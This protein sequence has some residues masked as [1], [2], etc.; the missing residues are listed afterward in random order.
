VTVGRDLFG[1]SQNNVSKIVESQTNINFNYVTLTVPELIFNGL[2]AATC[3][4]ADSCIIEI[5]CENSKIRS[6]R[7]YSKSN[8]KLS[9]RY[10]FVKNY[11]YFDIN[12]KQ[13]VFG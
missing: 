11:F 3:I 8:I 10:N 2:N 1:S 13:Y 7:R 9:S 4:I 12:I 5:Y 6:G